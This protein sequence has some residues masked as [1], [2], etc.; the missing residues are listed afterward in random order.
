M[1]SSNIEGNHYP[2]KLQVLCSPAASDFSQS[3]LN[4]LERR[5]TEM[6]PPMSKLEVTGLG[7]SLKER[8]SNITY[9]VKVFS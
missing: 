8:E 1:L 6:N 5:A 3:K 7:S 4:D 9:N 2:A